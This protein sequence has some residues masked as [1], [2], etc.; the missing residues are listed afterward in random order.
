MKRGLFK[1]GVYSK[2]ADAYI[3]K[4]YKLAGFI[5]LLLLATIAAVNNGGF[6][7]QYNI[8]LRRKQ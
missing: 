4:C 7:G 8:C 3:L 6:S 2:V 5:Q 1:M